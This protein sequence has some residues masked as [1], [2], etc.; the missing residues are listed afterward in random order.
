MDWQVYIPPPDA[1][2]REAVLRVHMKSVPV[3]PLVCISVLAQQM[4]HY[5]GAGEQL[6]VS[7]LSP[8]FTRFVVR[9]YECGS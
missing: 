1:L 8:S 9:D 4:Q 6:F 7:I 5:T 3:G 2:G